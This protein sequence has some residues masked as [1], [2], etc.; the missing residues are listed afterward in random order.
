MIIKL[1]LN[2]TFYH[3]SA[4]T[5]TANIKQGALCVLRRKVH[6]VLMPAH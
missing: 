2:V 1:F 3:G 5:A 4:K 6:L